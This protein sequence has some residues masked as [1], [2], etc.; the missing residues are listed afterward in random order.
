MLQKAEPE[1]SHK[2]FGGAREIVNGSQTLNTK[3]FIVELG[4]ALI[5]AVPWLFPPEVRMHLT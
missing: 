4:F 5:V 3:L 2:P 1:K